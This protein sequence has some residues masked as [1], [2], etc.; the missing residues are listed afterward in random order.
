MNRCYLSAVIALALIANGLV[1]G[2]HAKPGKTSGKQV[3]APPPPPLPP[4]PPPPPPPPAPETDDY[5]KVPVS[6]DY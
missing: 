2:A 5:V 1:A 6:P 3:P 4:P